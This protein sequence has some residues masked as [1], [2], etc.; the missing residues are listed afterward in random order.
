MMK[1][2]ISRSGRE[3]LAA[4]TSRGKRLVTVDDVVNGLAVNRSDAAKKLARWT[5]QGW[6]RRVRR[7]LYIPVPVDVEQP[8]LWSE[9]PL[10]LADAV[11]SPCYFTGW[12][13][14]NHWGLTEQIFRTTVVKTSRRVRATNQ[15]LLDHD[16]LI[17]HTPDSTMAW[18]VRPVWRREQR[19]SMA[20]ESRTVVDVLDDPG[21]G[22]GIRHVAEILSAY[23]IDFEGDQLL[24]YGERLGNRT[25]F[26]R[27]GYLI[28]AMGLPYDYLLAAC[29]ERISGGVSLLDPG[30][31][32][33]G[34]RIGEWGLRANVRLEGNVSV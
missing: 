32:D 19:V 34:P 3:E 22:G 5:E 7:G 31:S 23:L 9:D 28:E 8:E 11:W 27:M 21:I 2:G 15:R 29:R 17:G 16:Y 10:V 12:T 20:D 4:V 18:G 24:D 26:K 25:V 1:A 30:A 13:A 33:T 14:A 6:L